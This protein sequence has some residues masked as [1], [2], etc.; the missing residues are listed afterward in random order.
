MQG[1]KL[2]L[3]AIQEWVESIIKE[4]SKFIFHLTTT[5]IEGEVL[6]GEIQTLVPVG[7]TIYSR[8]QAIVFQVHEVEKYSVEVFE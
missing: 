8:C 4:G 2:L 7:V 5:Y 3:D 6:L 1:G